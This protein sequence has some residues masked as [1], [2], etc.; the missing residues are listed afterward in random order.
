MGLLF[1]WFALDLAPGLSKMGYRKD[2]KEKDE[3]ELLCHEEQNK[4]INQNRRKNL[5]LF[6]KYL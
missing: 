1:H 6:R 2:A 3:K 4:S 5:N